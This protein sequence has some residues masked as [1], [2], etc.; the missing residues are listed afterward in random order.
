VTAVDEIYLYIAVAE[1]NKWMSLYG[2]K[3]ENDGYVS[4]ANQ[5]DSIK[6]KS[7]TEK[8]TFDGKR[9]LVVFCVLCHLL[10]HNNATDTV[11]YCP[12]RTYAPAINIAVHPG[13]AQSA[14]A[15]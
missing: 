4:V 15:E 7:I 3:D 2:W 12:H 6:T 11:Q 10:F 1:T 13:V 8:I 9:H 5:E 14:V